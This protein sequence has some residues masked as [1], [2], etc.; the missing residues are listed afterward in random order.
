MMGRIAAPRSLSA[1]TAGWRRCSYANSRRI[2]GDHAGDA[3]AGEPADEGGVVHGPHVELAAGVA[4]GADERRRD[5]APVGH[6]RVAATLAEVAGG[7]GREPAAHPGRGAVDGNRPHDRLRVV[8]PD[9]RHRPAEPQRGLE[10]PDGDE[11]AHVHRGH[12]R[13]PD[14]VALL[15]RAHDARLVAGQLE[16][17]VEVD[18]GERRRGEVVEALLERR[19]GAEV[20]LVVVRQQQ[21]RG[22]ERALVLGQHVEL[23]HVDVGGQGGVEGRAGVAR[24]EVVGALV[25]DPSQ[26]RRGQV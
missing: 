17:D 14:E 9:A 1:E 19:R 24:R 7:G 18:A 23:D 20:V 13:A 8:A 16:V 5:E 6:H 12:E 21:A 4:D 26:A 22:V 2:V 11:A 15:Q 25:A 10:R 3:E